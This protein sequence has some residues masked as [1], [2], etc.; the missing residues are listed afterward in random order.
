[1]NFYPFH[2][3]DYMLRTAHLDPLEDVAYRR[4]IDLYYINEQRLEGTPEQLARVIRM[5]AHVEEVAAV[6]AEFFVASDNSWMHGHCEEV[7]EQ[8]Q[9]KAKL[10]SDNGKRG[11]RPKKA[12]ANPETTQPFAENNP[13]LNPPFQSANPEKSGREANQE[14]I[15][16]NQI[17]QKPLSP[18]S[19]ATGTSKPPKFNPL[20]AKPANVSADAW[21][22]WCA[23]RKKSGM[24]EK[25]CELIAKKLAG[26]HDPDAVLHHSIEN[27]WTRL[28]PEHITHENGTPAR[29]TGRLSAVD[30]V[31]QAIAEREARSIREVA[32]NPNRQAL[33]END[34]DVRAPL[35]GEFRHV[36]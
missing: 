27:G 26:H 33:A 2:P 12:G 21:A 31:K 14:P 29:A 34:R 36:G 11:G 4:L 3:G 28:L 24:T 6:L 8:Y 18:T 13:T 15:T 1:M 16:N 25:A 30:Q 10:A 17:D 32:T 20:T 35:D 7:I 5:K 22:D 23:H 19:S 9:V